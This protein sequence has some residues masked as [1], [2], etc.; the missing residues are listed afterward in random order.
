MLD[1]R[2]AL[3]SCTAERAETLKDVVP[4]TLSELAGVAET[5]HEEALGGSVAHLASVD[6][7]AGGHLVHVS[8]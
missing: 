2:R 1:A 6:R 3:R 8:V 5:E 7:G 4:G